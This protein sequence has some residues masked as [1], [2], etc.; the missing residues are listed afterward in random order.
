MRDNEIKDFICNNPECGT[1]QQG[2]TR[3]P[4]CNSLAYTGE[5]EEIDRAKS[6]IK[7]NEIEKKY[8]RENV[9]EAIFDNNLKEGNQR[10]NDSIEISIIEKEPETYLPSNTKRN[11]LKAIAAV[12]I[13]PYSIATLNSATALYLGRDTF[14]LIS[15][16]L[17]YEKIGYDFACNLLNAMNSTRSIKEHFDRR[18]SEFSDSEN[19]WI[20]ALE[21]SKRGIVFKFYYD[22]FK[23][24]AQSQDYE[25]RLVLTALLGKIANV[26]GFSTDHYEML[27]Q[28]VSDISLIK[29]RGQL[30]PSELILVSQLAPA[31][32]ANF[33]E[34]ELYS[35]IGNEDYGRR[36]TL[37]EMLNI[38][39]KFFH[40]DVVNYKN[41]DNCV[42]TFSGDKEIARKDFALKMMYYKV[43]LDLRVHRGLPG[44]TEVEISRHILNLANSRSLVN[45]REGFITLSPIVIALLDANLFH[46]AGHVIEYIE[47]HYA[48]KGVSREYN[49]IANYLKIGRSLEYEIFLMTAYFA[50]C[51]L[52]AIGIETPITLNS[53]KSRYFKELNATKLSNISLKPFKAAHIRALNSFIRENREESVT[54]EDMFF[55]QCFDRTTHR[56]YF[57]KYYEYE[58][59]RLLRFVDDW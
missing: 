34:P 6:I 38:S 13:H 46:A 29:S 41:F 8:F 20:N 58:S 45:P 59:I 49:D 26:N 31:T 53:S 37:N 17:T 19:D 50:C 48:A 51:I 52:S 2:L 32:Y 57:P 24:S 11:F 54:Q 55:E 33:Q 18:G 35:N 16:K 4:K 10:K 22:E 14:N 23:A 56:A 36:N 25:T 7:S 21:L 12:A 5:K 1:E 47:S 44:M 15:D 28:T 42:S 3:C 9:F 30:T 39:K 40:N 27:K 43:L